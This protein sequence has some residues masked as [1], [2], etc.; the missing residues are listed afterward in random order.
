MPLKKLKITK[1][2]KIWGKKKLKNWFGDHIFKR[3]R[4]RNFFLN[5]GH[6]KTS[7]VQ[8][9]EAVQVFSIPLTQNI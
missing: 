5:L 9:A 7:S 6:P 3:Q 8:Y 2:N 4:K 1:E